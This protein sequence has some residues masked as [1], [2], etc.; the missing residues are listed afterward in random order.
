MIINYFI[1]AEEKTKKTEF[2]RIV[3]FFI[4]YQDLSFFFFVLQLN[5]IKSLK[6]LKHNFHPLSF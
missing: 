4:F 2:D 6:K 1:S 3:N 5:K